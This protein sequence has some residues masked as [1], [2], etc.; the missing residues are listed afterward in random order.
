MLAG[1][2]E[3]YVKAGAP[4]DYRCNFYRGPRKIDL[5]MREDAFAWLDGILKP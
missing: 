5:Q 3:V 2:R 4:D 1:L